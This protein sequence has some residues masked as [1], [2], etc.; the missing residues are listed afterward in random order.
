MTDT[1]SCFDISKP[2]GAV[3]R[4]GQYWVGAYRHA[5]PYPASNLYLAVRK[6]LGMSQEGIARK[7][8]VTINQ[9]RYRERMKRM[10]HLAE[11]LWLH[12]VSGLSWDE[13][14]KLLNDC[15]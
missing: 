9:W 4:R 14:H 12:E 5:M 2:Y 3:G 15:A 10:Y 11:I 7:V 8:G 6:R 1:V 13:Y